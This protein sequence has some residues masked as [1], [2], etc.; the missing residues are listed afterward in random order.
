MINLDELA[1]KKPGDKLRDLQPMSVEE[2][3][4]YIVLLENEIARADAMVA[5][6]KTHKQGI[7]ALFGK[8]IDKV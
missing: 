8:P 2:L 1:P 6:K 3:A 4:A 7:E 5:Q